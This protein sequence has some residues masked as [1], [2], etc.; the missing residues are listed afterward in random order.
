MLLTMMLMACTPDQ[1][2]ASRGGQG[3]G[4]GAE[5]SGSGDS[6]GADTGDDSAGG[7]TDTAG[8][9]TG[10]DDTA[11][12]PGA[13]WTL[14]VFVNGDNDLET[15]ALGDL[16][17]MEVVGSTDEVN[18]VVQ[19]DRSDRESRADGDWSGA[20]RYL[21]T[22]DT[23][24]RSITSPVLDDLGVVDSGSVDAVLDFV[25]WG[26]EAY[27]ARRY[28][29]VL[30]DHGDG[31]LLAPDAD[32]T[33][34]ISHDYG[35]DTWLSVAGGDVTEI[36]AGAERT[37]GHPIDLMGFDA[38]SMQSWEV[39]SSVAPHAGHLVASQD[40]EAGDGWPYDTVLADLVADPGMDAAAL[41]ETIALRFHEIPDSTM[42]VLDLGAL[43]ALT[44]A[45]DDVADSVVA[46]G[47]ANAILRTAAEG[48]QGYDGPRSRD[49]DL[50]HL[51]ERMDAT[52]EDRQVQEAIATASAAAEAV[53]V[54][55]YNRGGAVKDS[56]G[57]SI[58]SPTEPSLPPIYENAAWAASSRWDEMLA[59]AAAE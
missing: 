19:L 17:E 58:F 59:A 49:H 25:E 40:Y 27:P 11:A 12:R 8:D 26:V 37:L 48:A 57:L 33:K 1:A 20:R 4:A 53:V 24:Q 45:L 28:A 18:V 15:Y 30:W 41:G 51:L 43:P 50:L 44:A 54:S 10:G 34:G 46:T 29:L 14:L 3:G 36:V 23:D 9:D 56:N 47:T 7:D 6:A 5:D 13:E 21:V 55:N 22:K 39:A 2:E 52:T 38:C 42:S 31:W 35:A 16:N 32:V